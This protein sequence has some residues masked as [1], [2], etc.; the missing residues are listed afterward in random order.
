MAVTAAHLQVVFSGDSAGAER[1]AARTERAFKDVTDRLVKGSRIITGALGTALGAA[2]YRAATKGMEFE[3]A[4]AQATAI[5]DL[6]AQQVRELKDAALDVSKTLPIAASEVAEGFYFLASAGY[7]AKTSIAAL[8]DVAR[9]AVAGQMDLG[10]ATEYLADAQ[11][12]LGLKTGD[13]SEKVRQLARVADVLTKASD[14]SNATIEQFAVALT[15][16][17]GAALRLTN[18]SIEEGAAVLAVYA[19]QGTKGAEAGERLH[20]LLRDLQGAALKNADAFKALGIRVY[21]NR[22]N[23]RNLADIIADFEKA[24]DGMSDKQK[25][26][27][28]ASLGITDRS[29]AA[30][31]ALLGTS[32]QIRDYQKALEQASGYTETVAGRQV[33]NLTDLLIILQNNLDAAGIAAYERFIQP[34]GPKLYDALKPALDALQAFA[35]GTKQMDPAV[36]AAIGA[37][38]TTAV[39]P[40]LVSLASTV[41]SVV[42][43]VALLAAAVGGAMY[44]LA[45]HAKPLGPLFRD[46]FKSMRAAIESAGLSELLQDLGRALSVWTRRF[47]AAVR[48]LVPVLR[49]VMRLLA[50]SFANGFQL[51]VAIIRGVL[52]MMAGDWRGGLA[53]IG[54]TISGAFKKQVAS[55]TA[56]VA[57]MRAIGARLLD[58]LKDG[59]ARRLA[60]FTAWLKRV[61]ETPARIARRVLQIRS[62]SK[63]FEDI[64]VQVARGYLNGIERTMRAGR[65]LFSGITPPAPAPPVPVAS[66]EASAPAGAQAAGPL[67]IH[68]A[69][70]VVNVK[71]GTA[72]AVHAELRKVAARARRKAATGGARW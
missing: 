15:N 31:T 20:M 63:V 36:L 33:R 68:S 64:G 18:K 51:L 46:A 35:E 7:D 10:T 32:A 45:R 29:V 8:D 2:F 62:P 54:R 67:V 27:A 72:D 23:L 22:G 11:A 38:I 24:L 4:V 71:E 34:L 6:S 39:L 26:A 55:L 30:T 48:A 21:D 19:D 69:T 1:A 28:I 53:L 42:G 13:T 9:F 57:E 59:I 25:R 17:A 12:A 41:L 44:L 5:V 40:A 61:F 47:S 43:P 37:A 70:F 52:R 16:K 3:K 50:A 66:S 65:D 49:P 56:Y 60:A 58:G 14:L